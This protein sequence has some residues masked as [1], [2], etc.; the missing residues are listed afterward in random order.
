MA[1]MT[2]A[3][4]AKSLQDGLNAHFGLEYSDYPE[5]F[6]R[7]FD[8]ET[9]E[10]AYEEDVLLV[11]F[12]YASEKAEGGEYAEDQGQ[13]GWTKRY[14]HRIVA[15]SFQV[16]EEAIE[17]NRYMSL[18][19]KYSRALARSMRQTK[20]VYAANVLNNAT[21]SG[22]TGGDGKSLL[23]TDHPLVGGGTASNMLATA[24]DLS[25]SSLEQILI[26]VRKAKDDRGLPKMIKAMQLIVAPDNEYNARRILGSD[27]QPGTANNDINAIK[28]KSVFGNEPV[29]LTNLTDP[30]AW[31]VKTDCPEGLKVLNRTKLV[32]PKVTIDSKTGNFLYRARERYSEGWTDWRSVYGSMGA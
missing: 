24:A 19:A 31:F 25:E 10:K 32:M 27:K 22:Y 26:Q 5:E 16:T 23:A 15:L 17:D 9:S 29:V 2:R 13:E 3:Q 18:G 30:D 11:G 12:G 6:S 28:S 4:F 14:T 20:E 7:V 1:I 21:D 8:V